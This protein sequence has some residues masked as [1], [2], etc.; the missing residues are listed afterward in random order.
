MSVKYSAIARKNPADRTKPAKFYAQVVSTGEVS[1]KEL[2]RRVSQI[3][4]IGYTD[5]QAVISVLMEIIPEEL[6]A[7]NT[8]RLGELGSLYIA[9]KSD[10][11]D[12][13]DQVNSALIKNAKV[14]FRPG[15]DFKKLVKVLDY[16]KK[17]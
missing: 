6:Q 1:L 13:E 3:S 14:A 2:A 5:T 4:T 12:K 17:A 15:S 9:H 10:G 7:G 16:E 8:V 11:V